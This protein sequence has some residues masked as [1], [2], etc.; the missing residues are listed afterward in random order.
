MYEDVLLNFNTLI[1]H[2]L[3]DVMF[4]PAYGMTDYEPAERRVLLF[5]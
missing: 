4:S 2:V 5:S 1:P 3:T